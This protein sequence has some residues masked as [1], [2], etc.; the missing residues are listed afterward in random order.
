MTI[1]GIKQIF[2]SVAMQKGFQ[3]EERPS[4]STNSYYFKLHGPSTSL[5]FRVSDHPT[6]DNIIT[7]RMDMKLN[8]DRVRG[9]ILNR[10]ADLSLR[11]RDAYFAQL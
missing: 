1:N 10:C 6:R 4:A 2:Q 9:F 8:P 5:M 7:L 3:L 11:Q